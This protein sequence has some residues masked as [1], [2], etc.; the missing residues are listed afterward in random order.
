MSV[1]PVDCVYMFDQRHADSTAY[2]GFDGSGRIQEHIRK[3]WDLLAAFPGDRH[4]E[5]LVH[6]YFRERGHAIPRGKSTYR[7][8]PVL[9]YAERLIS[10]GMATSDPATLLHLPRLCWGALNPDAVAYPAGLTPTLFPLGPRQ[11]IARS[12]EAG[13]LQSLSDEWY[14]PSDIIESARTVM[15]E[16][17]LDPASCPMANLVVKARYYFSNVISGLDHEWFGRVWLNPPFGGQASSFTDKLISHLSK[18]DVTEACVLLN[19]NSM[20][21]LWFSP[22]FESC[23]ALMTTNGR[24]SFRPGTVASKPSS[25]NSGTVIV[26]FGGNDDRFA[27]EF[28]KHG[29]IL[30]VRR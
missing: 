14:T 18:Q 11:R 13:F 30:S 27:S 2:I 12:S 19:M 8:E 29:T 15:G 22:I 1:S 7:L 3:G 26:Y 17:D 5:E 28:R 9:S 4:T 25:S 20:C 23:S 6:T 10:N 16:I 24:L 21:S